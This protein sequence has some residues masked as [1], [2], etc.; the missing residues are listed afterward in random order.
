MIVVFFHELGHF[1]CL[2][3]CG[4]KVST[5]SVGVWKTLFSWRGR[6]SGTV[7][8]VGLI[9][10]AGYVM[11]AESKN[12][13]LHLLRGQLFADMPVW[14]RFLCVLA[15]PFA[16]FLLC[17]CIL[18]ANY[19]VSGDRIGPPQITGILP[20]GSTDQA[21][22]H[23]GDTFVYIGARHVYNTR[24]VMEAMVTGG[25]SPVVVRYVD[26]HGVER[27]TV[28]H[29]RSMHNASMG[30]LITPMMGISMGPMDVRSYSLLGAMG[31]GAEMTY[32]YACL[33]ASMFK[34]VLTGGLPLRVSEGPVGTA[35]EFHSAVVGGNFAK[36]ASLVAIFSMSLGLMNI[37]PLLPL[38]GGRLFFL[39]LEKAGSRPVSPAVEDYMTRFGLAVV[40]L[41]FCVSVAIDLGVLG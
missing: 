18:S 10:F 22:M 25:V 26:G 24:D 2:R 20:G 27:E 1:L 4:A 19:Y 7:Y 29:P 28:I 15:G 17:F 21:G 32:D 40:C 5:F 31:H 13:G 33:S 41:S 36:L 35:K 39:I 14:K 12:E 11:P 23:V 34:S 3:A 6:R 9:P 38:D 16:S 30:G 37:V 8:R